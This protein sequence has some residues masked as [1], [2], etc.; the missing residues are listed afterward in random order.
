M[1]LLDTNVCIHLI[2]RRNERVLARI[3]Q[4]RPSQILISAIT[5]AELEYGAN[6]SKFRER[7]RKAL[8]HFL[9]PFKIVPFD[10]IDGGIFGV[11]RAGL[12]KKGNVIGTYDMLL[13]SQ[14]LRLKCVFVTNNTREFKRVPGLKLEDWTN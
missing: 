1:Y 3:Q 4:H 9:T 5:V 14:A 11:I 2:S 7:G 10:F 6:K 12:E 13:A 8:A